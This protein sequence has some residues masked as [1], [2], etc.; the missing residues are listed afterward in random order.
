MPQD[1]HE[2]PAE[3]RFS[4]WRWIAWTAALLV[5]LWVALT[6]VDRHQ[7]EKLRTE[8][9]SRGGWLQGRNLYP[10]WYTSLLTKAPNGW[11][12]Q[13][14]QKLSGCFL[15][16]VEVRLPPETALPQDFILR[17]SRFQRVTH[18]ELPYCHLT[19][20]DLDGL[21]KFKELQ[22]LNLSG[23]DV[24]DAGLAHLDELP[25]LRY[26]IFQ[27]TRV[28]DGVLFQ[29]S[30]LPNLSCLNVG[31]TSITDAGLRT[32]ATLPNLTALYLGSDQISDTG[33][34][35]VAPQPSLTQLGLRGSQITD[36]GLNTIDD[37]HFPALRHLDIAETQVTAEGVSR[38]R[39]SELRGLS[40]PNV[41]MTD[42]HWRDLVGLKTLDYA[43][44]GDVELR[45]REHFWGGGGRRIRIDSFRTVTTI[46]DGHRV[47][48]IPQIFPRS[49]ATPPGEF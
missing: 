13:A 4:L 2:N 7:M 35:S 37:V 38:L 41:T 24:T 18:L 10:G 3:P 49:A 28:G 45:R 8:V 16:V 42:E 25:D 30:R 26:L 32:L 5:G 34:A 21:S 48:V 39:L 20:A 12:K 33:L 14:V 19:D 46:R 9:E 1:D 44:W 11:P 17:L 40:F 29:A 23:N 36:K 6:A 47:P 15:R 31:E 22:Y 27:R 43:S